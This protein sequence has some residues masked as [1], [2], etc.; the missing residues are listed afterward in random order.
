MKMT[1]S[2]RRTL[3]LCLMMVFTIF[4]VAACSGK[5]HNTASQRIQSPA[6]LSASGTDSDCRIVKHAMGETC[7]PTN[8]QRVVTLDVVT[9]EHALAVGIKPIGAVTSSVDWSHLQNKLEG[10]ENIGVVGEPNLEKVLALKPDLILG[11]DDEQKIYSQAS[12]IA[13]TVMAKFENSGD[14]KEILA[15]VGET[16]GKTETA[17]RVMANYYTRLEQFKTQMGNRL[18]Q[19]EVSVVYLYPDVITLYTKAGFIGTVLEDAGLPR[20]PSQ[21]LNADATLQKDTQS[22]IQYRISRE[23]FRYADGDVMFLIVNDR[24]PD[25]QKA[26]KQLK[27]DPLWSQLNVIQQGKAYEV[28]DYWIGPGPLAANAVIDDLFKYLVRAL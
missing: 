7:V 25:I 21:S 10:I 23:L 28:P 13:P 8:P 4:L 18:N 12:Q 5:P 2:V 16:L 22:N 14:W 20:P 17:E 1:Q 9:L 3:R 27:A 26:L 24:D 15:L 19:T 6:S 11:I